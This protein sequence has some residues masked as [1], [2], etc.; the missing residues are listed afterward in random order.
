MLV[1]IFLCR[2][3]VISGRVRPQERSCEG[4][5]NGYDAVHRKDGRVCDVKR[6]CN[7]L[8]ELRELI[9]VKKINKKSSKKAHT[10]KRY[11]VAS[12]A[13]LIAQS[14]V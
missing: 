8:K 3:L 13:E 7:E 14:T 4:Y 6:A 9:K 11:G 2:A 5:R 10:E 12:K 1:A